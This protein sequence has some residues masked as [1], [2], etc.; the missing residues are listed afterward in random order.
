MGVNAINNS[1]HNKIGANF[2]LMYGTQV[3]AQQTT[4]PQMNYASIQ[5]V[6]MDFK[7]GQL[8]A[9]LKQFDHNP[10]A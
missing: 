4:I 6:N 1:Q 8:L 7:N 3:G 10:Q 5:N 2:D 9:N